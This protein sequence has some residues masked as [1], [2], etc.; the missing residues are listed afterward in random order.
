M[1]KLIIILVLLLLLG[2]GGAAAWFLYFNKPAEEEGAEEVVEPEPA[3]PPVY[4]E[5]N[6]MQFPVMGDSGVE[7]MVTL[8]IALQVADSNAGDDVI[9]MAPRLND[10]FMVKLYG[11]LDA[12]TVMLSNGMLDVSSIKAQLIEAANGVLGVGV[13]EDALVQMISQ[14]Q[15]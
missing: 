14:R 3:G 6:P 15:L 1:R 10:A 13:V 4:V 2:G 9:E 11:A 5:F 7:Q 12:R 8:V